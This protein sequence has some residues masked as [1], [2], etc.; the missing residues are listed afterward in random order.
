[1]RSGGQA[2]LH[3]CQVGQEYSFVYEFAFQR[4]GEGALIYCPFPFLLRIILL[5][6][7]FFPATD[8]R[9]ICIVIYL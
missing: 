7:L 9:Y 4:S 5:A 3:V 6:F 8:F 1:M 2:A